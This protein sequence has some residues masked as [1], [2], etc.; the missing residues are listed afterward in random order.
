MGNCYKRVVYVGIQVDEKEFIKSV[1]FKNYDGWSDYKEENKIWLSGHDDNV[2]Q[3][4]A[5]YTDDGFICVGK[6]IDTEEHEA[7]HVDLFKEFENSKF[8]VTDKLR[9]HKITIGEVRLYATTL[10]Y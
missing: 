6:I 3:F 2:G 9:Q 10:C 7:R 8:E 4:G 1:G 5:I